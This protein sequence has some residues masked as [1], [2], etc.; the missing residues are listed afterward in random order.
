M[1]SER[2]E[3]IKQTSVQCG[4][5]STR[6]SN[7]ELF[8]ILTML[9]IVAHHYVVNSGLT[10]LMYQDG[11]TVRSIFLF[12][13]GAWGKVGINCFVL[14]TGYFMCKSKITAHKFFKLLFEIWFYKIAIYFIFLAIRYENFSLIE[15]VKVLS[16]VGSVDIC[17]TRCYILFYLFIPF[18]NILVQNMT[19]KQHI[20]LL[21]LLT[22]IYVILGTIPKITVTF[23]YVTWFIVL[24]FIAAYLRTYPKKIFD[25][26]KFWG[27]MS[28]LCF[29]VSCASIV[30]MMIIDQKFNTSGHAF[31]FVIDCNKILAVV[32]SICWF[33][34]FKNIKIKNSK[35]INTIAASTFGVLLI[36]SGSDT[37]RQWLWK[38]LLNN[39]GMF[40]SNLLYVHAIVSVLVIF[41]VCVVIDYLRILLIEKPFLKW[42]DKLWNKFANWATKSTTDGSNE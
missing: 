2:V 40:D 36:H 26:T 34:F 14:I 17:F 39:V 10:D 32:D 5:I 4:T 1:M 21:V 6:N 25:S 28:L 18:L 15:F 33:M 27:W 23:N 29:V 37:M 7:L 8:R 24:Y 42:W 3:G 12:L 30:V 11:L 38:D 41:I 22:F 35:I 16:P 13:Y 31:Y 9:L 19:E 20:A